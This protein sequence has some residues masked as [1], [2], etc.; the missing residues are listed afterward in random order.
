[1]T[2]ANAKETIQQVVAA[3]PFDRNWTS[4]KG[5]NTP[6]WYENAKF[7][8][9]IHW[10][11]YSVPAFHNEW[12]PRNMYI[13]DSPDFKHHVE[14]YGPQAKFGYKDFIPL[15]TA[16]R[17]D[18]QHWAGLF[19]RAGAQFVMPVA[20]H[21]D[22]FAM[23]DCSFSDWKATKMGPKRDII[24]ELAAAV[25]EQFMIFGLSSHRAE[26]WWFFN[27]GMAFDSD[28]QDARYAGLY[29]P[30]Q[31]ET[32]PP[33]E[34]FLDD[35]L[36]RTCELVDK[37]QPQIVWF[38]WWIEQPIFEPYRQLFA[39]YYYNRG[40]QWDRGVAVN[41]KHDAFPQG[42]AVFDIERGQA[43]N[44]LPYFWQTDTSVAKT[45]WGYVQDQDYK[46]VGDL[47]GDLV[48]IV[49]K[50]GALLLNI[51]PRPDGT[52]P[53]PEEELLLGIGRWL[54][55]N[56]EAIYGTRPWKVFGEGP[57]QVVEG[58][59]NDTK[60]QSFTSQDLRFTTRGDT[61]Y[62]I[63]LAWPQDGRVTIK[64]LASDNALFSPAVAKVELLGVGEPLQ[65]SRDA[66][67]L[68][69]TLPSH[70]PGEHAFA[71]RITPEK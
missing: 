38:D 39:A 7:G 16:E 64:S 50:N 9:F 6:S 19:K 18:P 48:D 21:H 55:I 11:V 42:S 10:G 37:Y 58:S 49:S 62:A 5:Y 71:F 3:G 29:A 8:I 67:G 57:T 60:R 66:D 70:K 24:A 31:P 44:I 26:H 53:Q 2:V 22:G 45:S 17:F 41:Y 52:I 25:R 54:N 51:G 4:L 33:N 30:A 59:F 13:Q 14:T 47:I 69:I 20:E 34:E 46:T 35:W 1:M 23:Y 43:A 12:Y 28:V 63:A 27:G 61:L 68:T 40:A 32:L 65:W 15:F 36:A 56:G